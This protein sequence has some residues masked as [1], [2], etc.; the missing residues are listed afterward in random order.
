M[1]ADCTL[2]RVLRWSCVM[3]RNL[4]EKSPLLSRGHQGATTRSSAFIDPSANLAVSLGGAGVQVG[5]LCCLRSLVSPSP[6]PPPA[7]PPPLF[8]PLPSPSLPLRR[9]FSPE[10]LRRK[11]SV[12]QIRGGGATRPPPVLPPSLPSSTPSPHSAE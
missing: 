11:M 3:L 5:G 12:D 7:P 8:L 10:E 1:F 2:S 6:R 4:E 9:S